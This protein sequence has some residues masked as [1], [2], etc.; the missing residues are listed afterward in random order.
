MSAD[1]LYGAALDALDQGMFGDV[2]AHIAPEVQGARAGD[3][4][5][6][7][8]L[9]LAHRGLQDSAASHAAFARAAALAPRDPLVAHSLARTA[10]EA[11][12]PA[13]ALFEKARELAPADAPVL[14]GQAAARLAEGDGD[15]ACAGLADVLAANPGWIEGH[16]A[17]ARIAAMAGRA[18]DRSV[19]AALVRHPQD[20][21][22]WRTL[23]R[24]ALEA[25]QYRSALAI[26]EAARS[27]LGHTA[28]LARIEAMCTSEIG[29]PAT[30]QRLF[31]GLPDPATAA[32]VVAP[33]RNL[34]RLGRF[35]EALTLAGRRFGEDQ[36]LG[37]WPY[38]ALLW[39][40]TGDPRWKWLEGDERLIG[41]YDI[42]SAMGDLAGL[43][44]LLRHLHQ[45]V[46]R[47]L[48][49]SVRG[50]TQT[51]GNLLARAEPELRRLRAVLLDAV[52]GHVAQLPPPVPGHPTLHV[53]REPL[54]IAGAWSVRLSGA[55]FHI[56]HMHQQGW[57]SSAL[58]V[59]L[60]Q[61]AQGIGAAHGARR[62]AGWLAFG[63]NRALLPDLEG[64]RLVEPKVGQLVLFP[65]T[66]WHGTR[67]F[68]AGERLTVAFDI[69]R[70]RQGS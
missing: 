61:G 68:E 50:G 60:P 15:A 24:L 65:S 36:D 46:S 9:G 1:A 59:A 67:P 69:A 3:M 2:A 53:R 18:V 29:D 42:G 16:H 51:D 48:D 43:A 23:I 25:D 57:L 26:V 34:I 62:N 55:G 49:Q 38:R 35:E 44:D 5:F 41:V 22:L 4:R 54:R 27:R 63:E 11:G 19:R 70:P 56:D 31:A 40:I 32:E 37:L 33:L 21:A 10:L 6:W 64:F 20:P 45:G 7:Q 58:Y 39:R 28:E 66:M 52:A 13:S 14:L 8:L 47:P 17:F 12:W 30:A